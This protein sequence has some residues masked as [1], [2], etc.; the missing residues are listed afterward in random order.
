LETR[1]TPCLKENFYFDG[2][3]D[4]ILENKIL[5]KREIE[6]LKKYKKSWGTIACE[7]NKTSHGIFNPTEK[8]SVTVKPYG[9]LTPQEGL[10]VK[11]QY[12][13]PNLKQDVNKLL[14]YSEKTVELI[15]LVK[16][17]CGIHI[18]PKLDF[19]R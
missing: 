8:S 16:E 15:F 1:F 3:I 6:W 11:A 2:Y 4:Y 5:F 10:T 12:E 9:M 19:V 7:R 13:L 14:N 18:S 17:I